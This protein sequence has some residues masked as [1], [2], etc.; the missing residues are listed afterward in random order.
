MESG[1]G[2]NLNAV[3]VEFIHHDNTYT[4]HANKE[5]IV[6]AG[7]VLTLDGWF[8]VLTTPLADL[9]SPRSSSSFPALASAPF[10]RRRVSQSSSTCPASGRTC[11]SIFSAASTSVCAHVSYHAARAHCISCPELKDGADFETADPI[12]QPSMLAEAQEQ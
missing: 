3:G 7:C 2:G 9:S 4:V 1:E 11:R 10:S 12:R 8:V 5:V 6:S